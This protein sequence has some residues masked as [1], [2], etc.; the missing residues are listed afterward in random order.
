MPLN[1]ADIEGLEGRIHAHVFG[2]HLNWSVYIACT[3][4]HLDDQS[5][6]T[7]IACEWMNWPIRRWED[8]ASMSLTTASNRDEVEA[9]FYLGSHRSLDVSELTLERVDGAFRFKAN[10]LGKVDLQ[11]FGELDG[12]ELPLDVSAEAQF[13]GIVVVPD[14][15]PTKPNSVE[16]VRSVVAPLFDLR[17]L[18]DP[19]FEEFRYVLPPK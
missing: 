6:E 5:W 19:E 13:D 18:S 11:G 7:S 14:N 3:P 8:L 16:E 4:V 10:L 12:T 2:G 15:L 9:S 1:T 17:S